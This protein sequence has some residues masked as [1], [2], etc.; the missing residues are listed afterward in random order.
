MSVYSSYFLTDPLFRHLLLAS[1]AMRFIDASQIPSFRKFMLVSKIHYGLGQLVWLFI[2]FICS[3]KHPNWYRSILTSKQNS[4]TRLTG[5][6]YW[7]WGEGS[8]E[9][10]KRKKKGRMKNIKSVI[11]RIC[12][13]QMPNAYYHRRLQ[14]IFWRMARAKGWMKEAVS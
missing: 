8:M 1:W 9:R 12:I 6:W 4:N 7:S 10:M 13:Q 11:L 5:F 2:R 3:W 14:K